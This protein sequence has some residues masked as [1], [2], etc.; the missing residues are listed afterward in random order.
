[1][2]SEG[3]FEGCRISTDGDEEER[4]DIKNRRSKQSSLEELGVHIGAISGLVSLE[5]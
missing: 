1:M 5:C 3:F 4:L 2:V